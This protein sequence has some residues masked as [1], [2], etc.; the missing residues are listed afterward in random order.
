MNKGNE[1]E[2]S[3]SHQFLIRNHFWFGVAI[4][5]AMLSA[6]INLSVSWLIKRV[7]DYMTYGNDDLSHLIFIAVV[8]IVMCAF[9]GGISSISK[10]KYIK[11]AI[12]NYKEF[13]FDKLIK[14]KL[15]A[16]DED[17]SNKYLS[18]LT[19]D[20][21]M[22]EKNYL[23]QQVTLVMD[24]ILLIGAII[25]MINYSIELTL[26]SLLLFSIPILI[27]VIAGKKLKD[28]DVKVSN[29]NVLF[30]GFVKDCL[31]GF[32]LIK[33]YQSEKSI[34]TKLVEE[35]NKLEQSKA[36]SRYIQ[37]IV[38]LFSGLAGIISQLGLFFIGV[39]LANI[40]PTITPGTV[41]VFVQLM[42]FVIMPISE[43]PIIVANRKAAIALIQ[44]FEEALNSTE[45]SKGTHITSLKKEIV[46][47]SVSYIA[48][49]G[50]V[51][52]DNISKTFVLGKSYAVVGASG[53]GK[54]SLL[55]ILTGSLTNYSGSIIVDGKTVDRNNNESLLDIVT[56]IQ[57]NVFIF[58]A[59]I[60]DNITMFQKKEGYL[61]DEV[62]KKA[63]LSKLMDD[64]SLD[65]ICGEN[66]GALS[67]GEKQ[68]ISI[69]RCFLRN[70]PVILADEITAALDRASSNLLIDTLLEMKDKLR[71]VVTHK[72]FSEE[73][74]KY[75]EII[76][77]KDGR[78]V[79]YGS[80]D[81]LCN[82]KGHFMKMLD[83]D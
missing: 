15:F 26:S 27:S 58:N 35:N 55:K 12:K 50:K 54:T 20:M 68:R 74:T 2:K 80:Y 49:N 29:N 77:I 65:Y 40:N 22:I 67:G 56:L 57:Q 83:F 17:D 76:V 41:I 72:L 82:K 4:F 53:S 16:F 75:D 38:M 45:S 21:A 60:Y 13:A 42:N 31:V 44:K 14:K 78:I 71:I 66:G 11:R 37:G 18:A 33:E 36:E 28:A 59:S 32:D 8:I 9:D 10:P 24:V 6:V 79:E 73:L 70:T 52:L 64:K 43:I 5:A 23:D 3:L 34:Y 48:D 46:L 25:L 47:D 51:I 81:E 1:K 69:A 63:Q 39:Y 7:L 30:T 62:V 19:N 61:I